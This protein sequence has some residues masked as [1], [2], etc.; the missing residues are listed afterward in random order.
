MGN[1]QGGSAYAMA[2]QI[3]EG[4]VLVTERTLQRLAPGELTQLDFELDKLLRDLR[5]EQPP[6]DDVQALQKRNRR[7]QRLTS[8]RLMIQSHRQRRR[9]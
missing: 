9:A 2:Q 3:G 5:G 4:F 6:L 7:I 8:T 1:F